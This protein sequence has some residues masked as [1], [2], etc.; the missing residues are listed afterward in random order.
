[1]RA[2]ILLVLTAARAGPGTGAPSRPNLPDD[3]L[4]SPDTPLSP[5]RLG[6]A[7][8]SRR[9]GADAIVRGAPL[10]PVAD[11][12]PELR[13]VAG[14]FTQAAPARPHRATS[15]ARPDWAPVPP[16][17]PAS[18]RWDAPASGPPRR[19][20]GTTWRLLGLLMG[21]FVGVVLLGPWAW[22]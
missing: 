18:T 5:E 10:P 11:P 16:P 12:S 22:E 1:E 21:L 17:S 7:W 15:P 20:R 9:S 3:V 14:H 8:L 19:R 6:E 4:R 13:L 2:R